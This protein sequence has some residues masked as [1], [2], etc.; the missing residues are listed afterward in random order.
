MV[1][2]LHYRIFIVLFSVERTFRIGIFLAKLQAKWFDCFTC[3]VWSAL[4]CLK[5]QISPDNLRMMD[6]SCY[7]LLLFKKTVILTSE[8]SQNYSMTRHASALTKVIRSKIKVTRSRNI[9]G[10]KTLYVGRGQSLG[11]NVDVEGA[12]CNTLSRSVG[13]KYYN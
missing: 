1:V 10:A 3:P 6:N 2:L 11:G 8:L 4:S 5:V 7:S 13:Q 12:A 9:L